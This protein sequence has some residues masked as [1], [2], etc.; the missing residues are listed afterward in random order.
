VIEI[1]PHLFILNQMLL[2]KLVC[3]RASLQLGLKKY[4][5]FQQI[6]KKKPGKED[7]G[8]FLVKFFYLSRQD[9]SAKLHH[10]FT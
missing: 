7:A 6:A 8:F 9:S 1:Y 2:V 10:T 5:C 3:K 4:L